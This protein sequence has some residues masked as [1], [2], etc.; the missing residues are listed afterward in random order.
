MNQLSAPLGTVNSFQKSMATVVGDCLRY[1]GENTLPQAIFNKLAQSKAD[2][3]FVLLQHIIDVNRHSVEAQAILKPAWDTLRSQNL[4]LGSALIGVG[5]TYSRTLL[6]IL[7]LA[8][9]AHTGGG[10]KRKLESWQ[11]PDSQRPETIQALQAILEILA[12]VVAQGF[13]SLTTLLYEDATQISPVDFGLINAIL[14]TCL[15]VPGV[16]KHNEQLVTHFADD[17]T[18][19]YASTLLSW[20]DKLLHNNEPIYGEISIVFL[21]ELSS[22]P[23]LAESIAVNGTLSLILAANLMGYFRRPGGIGPFDKPQIMHGIWARGILPLA[24][25]LLTAIGA[26][27]AAEVACFLAQF[28]PQLDRAAANFDVK[29][30]ASATDLA[31]GYITLDMAAETHS[32]ALI[33]TL[34]D[35]FREAGASAGIISSDIVPLGWDHA[36]V[37]EDL[38][39]W[40]GR[41][42]ALRDCI[43]ATNEKEERWRQMKPMSKDGGA[44]SL[45]EEK[46]VAEFNAALRLLE[47]D[48]E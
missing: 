7:C 5:A 41:R 12:V 32:L 4:D 21:L 11:T 22:V 3:A 10:R 1:N 16:E 43:V 24:L 20:S 23:I 25:N 34:L 36:A 47:G 14:R 31:A 39:G 46:V 35:V 45:L 30:A 15:R 17:N 18:A 8:L 29:S 19:R 33:A 6:K 2:V 40:L 42:G 13:R 48:G 26:P 38:Y 28:R 9:Q 27:I 44:E 37:K